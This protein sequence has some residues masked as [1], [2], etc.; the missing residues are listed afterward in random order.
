MCFYCII[1]SNHVP[2]NSGSKQ[3]TPS[4]FTISFDDHSVRLHKLVYAGLGGGQ[5]YLV[6]FIEQQVSET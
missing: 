5:D 1:S 6:Y 4:V 3:T 2:C